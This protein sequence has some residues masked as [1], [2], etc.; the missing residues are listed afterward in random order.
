MTI[1]RTANVKRNIYYELIHVTLSQVLPFIV[2]SFLIYR[3]GIEYLGLNSL[4]SS[5]LS[6]LSLMELGFG[7]AAVY[8]MYSPAAMGDTKLI[9]AYLAHYRKVYQFIGITVLL[10]GLVLMPFLRTIIRDPV[11]PGGINL[12][13]CYLIFLSNAVIDYMLYGYMTALPIVFQR[14]DVLSRVSM[15]TAL[16]QCL[17]QIIVLSSSTSFYLYLF[18]LPTNT[19]ARNLITAHVVKKMYQDITCRGKNSSVQ[20]H[21]LKK[22]VSGILINKL[23]AV[24]RNSIDSLCI[25]AFFGLAMTGMYNNYFFVMTALLSFSGVVCSSMMAS[26]GNSIAVENKDKNYSNMRLFD[27]IYMAIAG[28][29]T[30]CM[31]CLYQPFILAWLGDK[32]MMRM[33]V[34]VGLCSYFYVLKCGDIRWVWHEGAGL[35]WESRYIMIAEGCVNIIL[36]IL[37]CKFLG[38][39]GIVFATVV[40]VFATN[41]I[42]CP[43]LIFNEYFKNSKVYEYW[44][45][46]I[47]YAVTM[48]IT[49]CLSWLISRVI[50]PLGMIETR[51][52]GSCILCLGGRLLVCSI[53]ALGVF[54]LLWCRSDRYKSAVIWIRKAV[55]I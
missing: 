45:D 52:I 42:L 31:L 39:T 33:P 17:L 8:S 43:K 34:V 50:F 25:S 30:V 11:L 18:I 26:V 13:V 27:F 4:F 14:R 41:L 38:V 40:S 48:V 20:K 44:I 24:S 51:D 10:M 9:C 47:E 28:W 3:W 7:T 19:I 49:A 15:L 6:V 1:G 32:M 16:L 46:H 53:I 36:N 5:V 2:R 22:R 54:W 35:W 12:Y 23:T 55:V 21:D 29:A 37:L